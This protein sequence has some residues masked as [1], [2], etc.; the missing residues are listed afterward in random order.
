MKKK[1][2][3]VFF[4]I[5]SCMLLS[6]CK[7]YVNDGVEALQS[8]DYEQARELFETAV[9]KGKNPGEAYKGLGTCY[10]ESADYENALKDFERSI[11]EGGEA[12]AAL[13]NMMG[14]S[15]LKTENFKKAVQYFEAGLEAEDMSDELKKEMSFNRIIAYEGA[16]DYAKAEKSLDQY[17]KSYPDD[18]KALKEKEFFAT[19]IK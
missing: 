8:G 7:N 19:Q 17:L 14:I 12:D 6:G 13:Y 2:K 5:A 10:F 9:E 18:E 4:V 11:G 16:K 1:S 3:I 15:S